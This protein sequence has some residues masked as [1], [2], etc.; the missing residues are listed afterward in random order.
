L[1]DAFQ[2]LYLLKDFFAEV[3]EG[4]LFTSLCAAENV[5]KTAIDLHTTFGKT[6]FEFREVHCSILIFLN[7]LAQLLFGWTFKSLLISPNRLFSVSCVFI[8]VF[9]RIRNGI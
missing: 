9:C 6:F 1:V 8:I 7:T 3:L 4:D 5:A 2:L